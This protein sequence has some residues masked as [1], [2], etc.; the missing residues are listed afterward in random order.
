[1]MSIYKDTR[2]LASK[3]VTMVDAVLQGTEPE[4]NDTEQ[5]DNGAIVVP[6]Y[7]CTPQPVDQSNYKELLIDGGYYTEDQLQ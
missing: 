7:L 2:L 6:S 4:I 1:T 3:A 5:Y